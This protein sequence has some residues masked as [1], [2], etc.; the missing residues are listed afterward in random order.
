MFSTKDLTFKLTLLKYDFQDWRFHTSDW[1]RARYKLVA[2]IIILF[3]VRRGMRIRDEFHPI[4]N[5]DA[6]AQ[7]TLSKAHAELFEK[8]LTK[9]RQYGHDHDRTKRVERN[10]RVWIR[11]K[12]INFEY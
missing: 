6:A 8:L 1:L 9:L 2:F 7:R 4:F 12:K 3:L 10:N 11:S 5:G